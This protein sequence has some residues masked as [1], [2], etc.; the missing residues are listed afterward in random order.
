MKTKFI[1]NNIQE[2]W[3]EFKTVTKEPNQAIL[4]AKLENNKT[5]GSMRN[6]KKL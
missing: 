3:K 2:E 5:D 6:A 1:M 4:E